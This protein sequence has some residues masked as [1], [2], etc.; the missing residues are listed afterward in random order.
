MFKFLQTILLLCCLTLFLN[1]CNNGQLSTSTSDNIDTI[2][3]PQVTLS[4]IG[5]IPLVDNVRTHK[6]Y[7]KLHNNS[8]Q[9]LLSV[10]LNATTSKLLNGISADLSQCQNILAHHECLIGLNLPAGLKAGSKLLKLTIINSDHSQ[11]SIQTL[12]DYAPLV[13]VNSL[14]VGSLPNKINLSPLSYSSSVVIPFSPTQKLS[15]LHLEANS[16]I[17]SSQI[18]C[19]DSS[20]IGESG[21]LCSAILELKNKDTNTQIKLSGTTSHGLIVS[22]SVIL[23][24]SLNNLANLITS[25]IMPILTPAESSQSITVF[26]NGSSAATSLSVNSGTNLQISNNNCAA[27]LAS[28]SSCSFTLTSNSSING[29]SS[30]SIGYF[31]G[32]SSS[33]TLFNVAYTTTTPSPGLQISQTNSLINTPL[34]DSQVTVLSFY[35][36]GDTTLT[37]LT[38]PALNS[39][40]T[41]FS[42][43]NAG[44]AAPV[45]STTGNQTLSSGASCNIGISYAPTTSTLLSSF[46][47]NPVASYVNS[48]GESLTYAASSQTI[49]YSS[50]IASALYAGNSSGLVFNESTTLTGSTPVGFSSSINAESNIGSVIYVGT[51]DSNVYSYDTAATHPA[52]VRLGRSKVSTSAISVITNIGTILYVG[53]FGNGVYQFDTT[54]V[55]DTWQQAGISLASSSVTGLVVYDNTLYAASNYSGGGVYKE[56]W[57][58]WNQVGAD[59]GSPANMALSGST[60]LVST[61]TRVKA[62]D[63]TIN[64][65]TWNNVADSFGATFSDT[66]NIAVSGSKVYVGNSN[67]A[68]SYDLQNGYNSMWTDISGNGAYAT[69]AVCSSSVTSLT[70]NGTNLYAGCSDGDV[71][72]HDI[73]QTTWMTW[74]SLSSPN[75]QRVNG[76]LSLNNQIYAAS[77]NGN[78]YAYNL[79]SASPRSWLQQGSLA[80]DGSAVQAQTRLGNTLYAAT[81]TGNVFSFDLSVANASWQQVGSLVDSY[82]IYSLTTVGSKIIAGGGRSQ[83]HSFDTNNTS[84]GWQNIGNLIDSSYIAYGLTTKG[85]TLYVALGAGTNSYVYKYDTSVITGESWTAVSGGMIG[86]LDSAYAVT[87]IGNKLYAAISS[88]LVA[89]YDLTTSAT[90]WTSNNQ[91]DGSSVWSLATDGSKLYAG[92]NSGG[93]FVYDTSLGS[94][95]WVRMCQQV[96]PDSG[97]VYSLAYLGSKIYAATSIGNVYSCD[98]SLSTPAWVLD[99]GLSNYTPSIKSLIAA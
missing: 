27:T 65:Q 15:N 88:G 36:N 52:W 21:A 55:N 57:V 64:P 59:T 66:G 14:Q 24:T 85:S 75:N 45:C 19:D 46:L 40:S 94:P 5:V 78:L 82:G 95:T 20:T 58:D 89:S 9:T 31:D 28:N 4:S 71:Y 49:T 22:N 23:T 96:V 74:G 76:L 93:V 73:T 72:V 69:G 18:I 33:S 99:P 91:P 67:R 12:L 61:G 51:A 1:A 30:V 62:L 43:T 34:N 35:N 48:N 3:T 25:A 2:T 13:A 86:F 10:M 90:S 42:Y 92:T 41:A 6:I 17:E 39:L 81:L 32:A 38:L 83:T 70:L 87:S 11:T 37:N 79:E 54:N 47:F 7:L 80:L 16:A 60:I 98:T 56:T 77:I 8:Q 44:I 50:L 26:N 53:T 97:I 68:F 84:A 29:Q 63:L